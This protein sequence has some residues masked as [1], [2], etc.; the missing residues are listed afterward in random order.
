MVVVGGMAVTSFASADEFSGDGCA[1]IEIIGAR[2]TTERPGMGRILGPVAEELTTEL[3]AM[4]LT[5][6]LNYPAS[7]NYANSVRTGVANLRAELEDVAANC[8]DTEVIL[9]GYSQGADV[10]GDL[11]ASMDSPATAGT[12]RTTAGTGGGGMMSRLRGNGTNA[13]GRMMGGG[14]MAR[15]RERMMGNGTNADGGMMAGVRERMAQRLAERMAN[16]AGNRNDGPGAGEAGAGQ[17]G[18]GG[19][20]A[21]E[22]GAG[23]GGVADP[24]GMSQVAAVVLFGDPTFTGGESFNAGGGEGNGIFARGEGALSTFQDDIVSFCNG[25]DPICQGRGAGGSDGGHGDYLKFSDDTLT[26]VAARV[27][28]G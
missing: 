27:R 8:P 16:R 12:A 11:L 22:G 10:V 3:T 13:D 6:P 24:T 20:G 4:V 17:G 14:M 26:F 5:T 15:L 1:D 7:P 2:G 18:A 19:G 9:M 23:Q 21:G 25:G 28:A